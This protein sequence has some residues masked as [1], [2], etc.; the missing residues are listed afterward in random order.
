MRVLARTS[1]AE[2]KSS[3]H[4]ASRPQS[5]DPV[6]RASTMQIVQGPANCACGGSCPRCAGDARLFGKTL[7]APNGTHEQQADQVASRILRMDSGAL[8]RAGAG[9]R[10]RSE[11]SVGAT[12]SSDIECVD[13]RLGD[14]G[15]PLSATQRAFFEP[16]LGA[17]LSAVRVHTN[18]QAA[19]I[20]QSIGAE[21]FTIGR[22]IVF[23]DEQYRPGAS[24]GREL[25]AHELAH[26]VQQGAVPLSR[27]SPLNEVGARPA[28]QS[29]GQPMVMRRTLRT[30]RINFLCGGPDPLLRSP[31]SGFMH[32]N[33]GETSI[34][35]ESNVSWDRPNCG[36]GDFFI[37][38]MR[39]RSI[40]WDANHGTKTFPVGR[41][42][43]QIWSG[44]DDDSDYYLE[45]RSTSTNPHC[46]LTG[47]LTIATP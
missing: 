43:T 33:T 34:T 23:G 35:I 5:A 47:T 29:T 21:A 10:A 8:L 2:S 31:P 12:L 4:R 24:A 1:L 20:S 18:R 9:D 46:C 45:I 3:T 39:H 22:H 28:L 19:A 13:R 32:L 42:N 38:L 27:H 25:L 44:V 41:V 17:D 6:A 7:G 40:L 30:A 37:T 15:V 36:D 11:A 26:V 16:R 14:A